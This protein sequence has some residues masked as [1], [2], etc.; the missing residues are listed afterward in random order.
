MVLNS[1]DWYPLPLNWYE[2]LLDLTG[3]HIEL[4]KETLAGFRNVFNIDLSILVDSEQNL[5]ELLG[6][7]ADQN[8]EFG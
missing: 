7:H 2:C 4:I 8:E 6:H 3:L 1:V 5:V